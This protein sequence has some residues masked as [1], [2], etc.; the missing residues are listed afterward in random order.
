[1]LYAA[2]FRE[3]FQAAASTIAQLEHANI[4][5]VHDYGVQDNVSYLVM[6]LLTGGTLAERLRARAH[7]PL[8]L[9]TVARWPQRSTLTRVPIMTAPCPTWSP[10]SPSTWP[11]V[12]SE[13]QARVKGPVRLTAG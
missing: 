8:P 4:I 12:H 11:A 6:R 13:C 5:P 9:P 3:R 10:P 1:M 7:V 2:D